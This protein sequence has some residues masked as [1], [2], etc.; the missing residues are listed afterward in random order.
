MHNYKLTIQYDGT[1]YSGWQIQNNAPTIQQEI[2]TSLETILQEKINLIGSGRTDA[3]VHALGQVANFRIKPKLDIYKIQHALNSLLPAGIAITEM[4]EVD[5]NFHSR[6]D[7]KKR[8]YIYLISKSKSP[9]YNNYSY[10]LPRFDELDL[11]L[12]KSLSK[13]LCSEHDFTSF[14]RKQTEVEN[15]LCTVYNIHWKNST[16]R[17]IFYIEANR[18][19]H[20]MVRTIIGTLLFASRKELGEVYIKNVLEKKD[21]EAAAESV[22][23]KG[24]FLFK[25]RY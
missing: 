21:R 14:A 9:F 15:K 18:F 17:I 8:S 22:P 5:E 25:V 20:G 19:L 6:F 13:V 4:K 1:N 12:L 23:A 24:L 3:G 10:L 16:D 11:K 2:T 7:A